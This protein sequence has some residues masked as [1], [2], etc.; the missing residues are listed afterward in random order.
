M[1]ELLRIILS[2]LLGYL[3]VKYVFKSCNNYQILNIK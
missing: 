2:I 1:N 3:I